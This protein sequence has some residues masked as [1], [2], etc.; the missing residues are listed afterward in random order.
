M[1]G[2]GRGP[3]TDCK[4]GSLTRYSHRDHPTIVG[5]GG[6]ELIALPPI[7]LEPQPGQVA[8][9][10]LGQG[11][12]A[13]RSPNGVIWLVDPYLSDFGREGPAVRLVP[14]PIDPGT[15]V[16]DAVLCTHAHS[17]HTDP[18]SLGAIAVVSPDAR[19]YGCAEAVKTIRDD[20]SVAS[21]QVKTVVVGDRNVSVRGM[22]QPVS[23][24]HADVVFAEH[25]GDACGFVFH[26][27]DGTRPFRIYVTGDTLYNSDL[28]SEAT[29]DVDLLCV[30]INGKWGNMSAGE[31]ARLT[32]ETGAKRVIPMHYGV[33]A[34]NTVDPATFVDEVALQGVQ[35]Q[36]RL[37]AIGESWLLSF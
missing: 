21:R 12:F 26:V 16:C 5:V 13:F 34:N 23:D 37:L 24:V 28:V 17:D 1:G 6:L 19:F 31:A 29:R 22:R 2:Y 33:M 20:A 4:A 10:W 32:G 14:P 9:R 7:T 35:A 36:V 27:G 25:S 30:C 18:V 15:V 11:G 8:V 3:G